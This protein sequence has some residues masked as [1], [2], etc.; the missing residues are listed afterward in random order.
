[1]LY[2]GSQKI[3]FTTVILPYAYNIVTGFYLGGLQKYSFPGIFRRSSW[4]LNFSYLID[5][6][7]FC[8][9]FLD[10]KTLG[11]SDECHIGLKKSLNRLNGDGDIHHRALDNGPSWAISS[12]AAQI[13]AFC[14]HIDHNPT[15]WVDQPQSYCPTTG[16]AR[17]LF[18]N[19][20]RKGFI[21]SFTK[22]TIHYLFKKY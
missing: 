3:I 8:V 19:V 20:Q 13:T 6:Q 7:D 11:N 12:G 15:T 1:M 9:L 2:Y 21:Y 16:L 17:V 4:N 5:G 14:R 10:V 18:Q 22:N